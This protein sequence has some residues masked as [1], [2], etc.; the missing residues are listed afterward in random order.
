MV[1][2]K[3]LPFSEGTSA[4]LFGVIMTMVT[5]SSLAIT[6]I[7]TEGFGRIIAITAISINLA[8]GLLHRYLYVFESGV[9]SGKYWRYGLDVKASEDRDTAIAQIEDYLNDS[10]LAQF[11]YPR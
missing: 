11:R 1:N 8:H 2:K 10:P 5:I 4:M 9:E 6:G 7:R 3:R